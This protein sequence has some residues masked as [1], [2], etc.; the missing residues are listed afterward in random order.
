[1]R[2]K[3]IKSW[4]ML[5]IAIS[6]VLVSLVFSQ[7][8]APLYSETIVKVM[9][10]KGP[11]ELLPEEEQ[12]QEI[13]AIIQNGSNRG[14]ALTF[15]TPVS[16]SE[17]VSP[18]YQKGDQLFIA[19]QGERV[20]ITNVKRDR[21]VLIVLGLFAVAVWWVGRKRGLLS[22]LSVGLNI[23]ILVLATTLYIQHPQLPL[24]MIMLGTGCITTTLSLLLGTGWNKK[25]IATVVA[26]LIASITAW[27]LG[28]FVINY[29]H[30]KGLRYE[31]MQFLTRPYRQIFIASLFLGTLG[32]A[33]DIAITVISTVVE[34]LEKNPTISTKELVKTGQNVGENVMGSMTSVLLFAYLSGGIP[35]ILL[36]LKNDWHFWPTIEMTLSLE[37]ARALVGGI[38]IVLTIPISILVVSL[39]F[40]KRGA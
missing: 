12:I 13:Q 33:M 24:A 32:A 34:V 18:L 28:W 8:N 27:L 17:G 14:E 39:L 9:T 6:W 25:T 11:K 22:L 31:D 7:Y 26:T 19:I 40:R 36:Y 21:Y 38:G 29:F 16:F 15:V 2:D 37:L 30:D 1:M 4:A 35:T 10:V 20:T 3:G 5:L 23:L